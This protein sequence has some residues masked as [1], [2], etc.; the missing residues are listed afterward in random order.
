LDLAVCPSLRAKSKNENECAPRPFVYAVIRRDTASIR[1]DVS[2]LQV[3]A[4]NPHTHAAQKY[5]GHLQYY[6]TRSAQPRTHYYSRKAAQRRHHDRG[7]G[8][9]ETRP[10]SQ[11]RVASKQPAN[12]I[13]HQQSKAFEAAL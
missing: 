4:G 1:S 8:Q 6:A 11:P 10:R 3:S 13:H 2:E 9:S 5:N 7:N 12:I